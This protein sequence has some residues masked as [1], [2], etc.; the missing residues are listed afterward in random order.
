MTSGCCSQCQCY[1]WYSEHLRCFSSLTICLYGY[2]HI[3]FIILCHHNIYFKRNFTALT[4]STIIILYNIVGQ[5]SKLKGH[6]NTCSLYCCTYIVV[7]GSCEQ[8]RLKQFYCQRMI[9]YCVS[10]NSIRTF[11]RP[12]Y[13]IP[14]MYVD[15]YHMST[16]AHQHLHNTYLAVIFVLMSHET[17]YNVSFDIKIL[18]TSLLSK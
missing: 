11:Y 5:S 6:S 9:D 8:R 4:Q 2:L 18:Y 15:E 7:C 3:N 17:T 16:I 1:A 10:H 12:I 14:S 13:R